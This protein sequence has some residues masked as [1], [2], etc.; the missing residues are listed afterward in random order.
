MFKELTELMD[1]GYK[2]PGEQHLAKYKMLMV[3][4]EHQIDILE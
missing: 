2:Q 3:G 4:Q 1:K